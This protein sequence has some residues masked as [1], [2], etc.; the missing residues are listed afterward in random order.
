MFQSMKIIINWKK[1][2]LITSQFLM[3]TDP[4]E[5]I[6]KISSVF[7]GISN[8]NSTQGKGSHC[9]QEDIQGD[10]KPI[11]LPKFY[12]KLHT[13]SKG[14]NEETVLLEQILLSSREGYFKITSDVLLKELVWWTN[15]NHMHAPIIWR[16]PIST[17]KIQ[18]D[19]FN[20]GWE[21]H[22][23]EGHVDAG[24]WSTLQKQLHI[25]VKELMVPLIFLSR[26]RVHQ[27]SNPH[28]FLDSTL[29]Q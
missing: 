9:Q 23:L 17:T 19:A 21:F 14:K 28:F 15:E 10:G 11:R 4:L 16:L 12:R 29:G 24:Q 22:S 5:F 18:T 1:V 6:K 8:N 26:V 13:V 25:N 27:G 7:Q 2:N 20:T 3:V